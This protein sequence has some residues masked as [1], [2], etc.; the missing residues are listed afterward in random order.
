MWNVP[1]FLLLRSSAPSWFPCQLSPARSFRCTGMEAAEM[2][3]RW[4]CGREAERSSARGGMPKRKERVG[5][6]D[7]YKEE[8]AGAPS[9][10]LVQTATGKQDFE[11]LLVWSSLINSFLCLF[12]DLHLQV[13][14][15][16]NKIKGLKTQ[17]NSFFCA[18]S[19]S[20]L[21]H[22][23]AWQ[24]AWTRSQPICC[25]WWWKS[26][27][28]LWPRRACA[29]PDSANPASVA[30]SAASS[31]RRRRTAP[32]WR[33]TKP[34]APSCRPWRAW[35]GAPDEL[36]PGG[37]RWSCGMCESSLVIRSRCR[38]CCGCADCVGGL[39][40]AG[41]P[42]MAV[43]VHALSQGAEQQTDKQIHWR[44][45]RTFFFSMPHGKWCLN[46]CMNF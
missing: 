28:S 4:R 6:R 12:C 14:A 21:G 5:W 35:E 30:C 38:R 36:L 33:R 8:L 26:S 7:V 46:C 15:D 39:K 24:P 31:R 9:P 27:P 44:V 32:R 37:A 23:P 2:C 3:H 22:R 20:H 43:D 1:P 40:A 45:F 25:R 19:A 41:T 42:Y 10:Q 29:G 11:L 18:T 13:T 16:S 17:K 34:C